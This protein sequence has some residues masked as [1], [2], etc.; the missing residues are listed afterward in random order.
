MRCANVDALTVKGASL[1]QWHVRKNRWKT[2]QKIGKV[3]FAKI[4]EHAEEANNKKLT[5]G[6]DLFY[7]HNL[8]K[9]GMTLVLK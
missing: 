2:W 7:M 1:M 5:R 9:T 3:W 8:G 6:N 4:S